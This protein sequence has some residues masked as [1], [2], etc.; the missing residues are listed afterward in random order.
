LEFFCFLLFIIHGGRSLFNAS[1]Y[2][3]GGKNAVFEKLLAIF[4]TIV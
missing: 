1:P 3:S 2:R 4:A